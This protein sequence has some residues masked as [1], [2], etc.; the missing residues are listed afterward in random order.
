MTPSTTVPP[1]YHSHFDETFDLQS[2]SMT[3]FLDQEHAGNSSAESEA[4]WLEEK[5]ATSVKLQIG[6]PVTV[7]AH[8]FHQYVAGPE[9]ETLLRV[10]LEPGSANFE[11]MLMILNGLAEDGELEALG[12]SVMLMVVLM[13]LANA[14]LIGPAKDML[15]SVKEKQG[16]EV[17]ELREKLLAKY[18]NEESLKKL[19]AKD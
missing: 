12:D 7:P 11:K 6:K 14:N 16:N 9:E 1:H 2:G 17:E 3:V 8:T 19:L 10:I 4:A 18:D 13:D 15:V 5:E